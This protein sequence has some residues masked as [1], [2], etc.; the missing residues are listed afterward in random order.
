[1]IVRPER[2]PRDRLALS[3]ARLEAAKVLSRSVSEREAA[4]Y[5]PVLR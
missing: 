5:R 1:M 3:E 4:A 2:E